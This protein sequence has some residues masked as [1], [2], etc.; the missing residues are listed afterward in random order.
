MKQFIYSLSAEKLDALQQYLKEN[1]WKEFI[2][3]SQ[4]LT[5]Y[6]ILFIL[7]SN[8]SLKLCVNYRTL[9]NIMIKNSYS[10]SLIAEL[11][12][13]LQSVQWF[14]KF[15]IFKAF[16]WI[17]IKEEDEWKTV[18]HSQLKHYEYLIMSFDLINASVTF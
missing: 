13:R 11:Q 1:L 9:N 10:L 15:N 14:T 5:E 12:N 3:K 16:N 17:W 4:L 8:E 18:F 2:R 6:S 7:K